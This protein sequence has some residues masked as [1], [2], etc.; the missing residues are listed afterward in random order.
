MTVHKNWR[1]LVRAVNGSIED[2][3]VA[4]KI[5][6]FS[7]IV[8]DTR[9]D[10]GRLRGNWVMSK[11]VRSEAILERDDKTGSQVIS[12]ITSSVAPY[13]LDVMTNNLPYAP[14]REEKDGMIIKNIARMEQ[15]FRRFR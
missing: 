3:L 14:I 4:V 9:V 2:S 12:E 10:T 1:K 6:L 15:I 8:L 5:E 11:Q 13:D 7:S